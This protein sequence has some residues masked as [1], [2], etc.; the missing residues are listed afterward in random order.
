LEANLEAGKIY[1]VHARSLMGT[2]RASVQLRAIDPGVDKLKRFQK[3]L[4]ER[5]NWEL[6][7]E[8]MDQLNDQLAAYKIKGLER[9]EVLKAKGILIDSLE[10]DMNLEIGELKFVQKKK[11]ATQS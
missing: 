1:I 8:K 9:F 5:S 3:L 11:R 6:S 10:P 2:T 4:A 7:H